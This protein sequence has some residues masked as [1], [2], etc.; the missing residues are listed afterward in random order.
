MPYYKVSRSLCLFSDKS[1]SLSE[2]S[3]TSPVPN[4]KQIGTKIKKKKANFNYAIK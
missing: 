2:V 4:F 3:W 1:Q